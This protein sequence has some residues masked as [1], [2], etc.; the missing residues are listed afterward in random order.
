MIRHEESR[1]ASTPDAHRDGT[2]SFHPS[3][4]FD[5][6]FLIIYWL[7]HC[8]FTVFLS[9]SHY[10]LLLY[11]IQHEAF[12]VTRF[13]LLQNVHRFH[14][15]LRLKFHFQDVAQSS[16]SSQSTSEDDPFSRFSRQPS[17]RTPS[18][19][20]SQ[21]LDLYTDHTLHDINKFRLLRARHSNLT[22]GERLVLSQLQRKQ[23]TV[24]KSA[25]KDGGSSFVGKESYTFKKP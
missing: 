24:I 13:S 11:Y 23:G 21:S 2:R 19:G 1:H 20:P 17:S 4:R 18:A 7:G 22:P 25:D 10:S 12:S 16:P 6:Y 15:S 3:S 8:K 5:Y 9:V 14:Y